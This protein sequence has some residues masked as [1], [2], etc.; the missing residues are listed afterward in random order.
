MKAVLV[1]S[2]CAAV[3]AGCSSSPNRIEA[4]YVSPHKYRDFTCS[5]IDTELTAIDQRALRLHKRLRKRAD[6][7]A[8]NMA[9][10]LILVWPMLLFLSGGDGPEAQEY[11][12]IKGERDALLLARPKCSTTTIAM[13]N[14]PPGSILASRDVAVIPAAT[15]SGY[16]IKAPAGYQGTGSRTRPA[17]TSG[18]P[19]C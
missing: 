17:I 10:G 5:E 13:A 11:A 6:K 4:A 9:A 2:L 8:Q 15:P 19:R 7:D 3:V 14:N 12:Q 18:M 16:C 1:A